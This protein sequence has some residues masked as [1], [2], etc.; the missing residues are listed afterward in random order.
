M[1]RRRRRSGREKNSVNW[2]SKH[3][4]EQLILF[5]VSIPS[6]PLL[7]RTTREKEEEEGE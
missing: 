4:D 1:R 3:D 5:I 2:L 7:Q 6:L